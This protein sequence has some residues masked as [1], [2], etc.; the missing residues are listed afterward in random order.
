MARA[1]CTVQG[2]IANIKTGY[3]QRTGNPY[4]TISLCCGKSVKDE[5]TGQYDNT[6]QQWWELTAYGD[7]AKALERQGFVKGDAVIAQVDDPI[8]HVYVDKNQKQGTTISATLWNFSL[9]RAFWVKK[10]GGSS[11][12]NTHGEIDDADLASMEASGMG[13]VNLADIPF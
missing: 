7:Y 3:T 2:F 1:H 6:R 4:F 10:N 13:S 5:Q 8:A 11:Q 9:A 12:S